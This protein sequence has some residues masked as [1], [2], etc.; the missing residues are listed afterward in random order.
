M[1]DD[2]HLPA[3]PVWREIASRF[4][5]YLN[6]GGDPTF[7]THFGEFWNST[8][9][10]WIE[11]LTK[12]YLP[13]GSGFDSGTQFDFDKSRRERLVFH[14]L[15]HHMDEH[16]GYTEW[17]H[18]IV[19]ITP[20]LVC[21]FEV[22]VSGVNKNDIKEYIGDTFHENLSQGINVQRHFQRLQDDKKAKEALVPG[23]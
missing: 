13:H 21:G 8:H 20:S 17:T 18:H 3:V 12:N 22:K 9:R 7:K 1:L 6:T 11:W 2:T 23:G 14:T 5:S 10:E 4:T 16:G 19:S 15:F